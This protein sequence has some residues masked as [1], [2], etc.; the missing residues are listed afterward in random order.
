M[1]SVALQ[2]YSVVCN[3]NNNNSSINNNAKSTYTVP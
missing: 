3:N 2:E 1:L